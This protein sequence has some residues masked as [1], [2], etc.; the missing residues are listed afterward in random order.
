MCI[1]VVRTHKRERTLL[2]P[3]KKNAIILWLWRSWRG[4]KLLSAEIPALTKTI[5]LPLGNFVF[6][7]LL[8][9]ETETRRKGPRGVR[10]LSCA[11]LLITY[12]FIRTLNNRWRHT[13]RWERR[14]GE[15]SGHWGSSLN[16]PR[17]LVTASKCQTHHVHAPHSHSEENIERAEEYPVTMKAM[18]SK[19]RLFATKEH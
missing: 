3:L 15:V 10:L 12:I 17:G 1:S 18:N 9:R 14:G 16:T 2:R 7:F 8:L 4:E 6:F 5:F 19:L 11:W 13:H